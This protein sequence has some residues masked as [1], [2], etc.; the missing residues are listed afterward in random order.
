[1]AR[2]ARGGARYAARVTPQPASFI[3]ALFLCAIGLFLP[4]CAGESGDEAGGGGV[5]VVGVVSDL[6][7]GVDIA[8][9]RVVMRQGGRVIR[10]EV[11]KVS[12][13]AIPLTFPTE[14]RFDGLPDGEEVEVG[15]EAFKGYYSDEDPLVVRDARTR[16]VFGEAR[17]LRARI[18]RECIP[19]FRL[20][21]DLIA[22]ECARPETCVAAACADPYVPPSE[23]EAYSPGWA[24]DF[25]DACKGA[26]AGDPEILIGEGR[27]GYSAL[28]EGSV[29]QVEG[30]PQGGF[31]IWVSVRMRNLHQSGSTTAVTVRRQD[32]DDV[33]GQ[34]VSSQSYAAA[35]GEQCELA[36]LRCQLSLQ[37]ASDELG[38]LGSSL[39]VAASVSDLAGDVG[40]AEQVIT[41]S[42]DVVKE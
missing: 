7:P 32:T 17:L 9:L 4:G 3:A 21:G 30:G 14:L 35:G 33:L 20:A 16:A 28:S 8:R 37:S 42:S 18:E 29:V 22:P 27:G 36:G 23:L 40:I 1:M 41:L 39:R 38:L 10:D 6:V 5:I 12:G 34:F 13:G 25:V 24:E 31:H 15:L 2:A 19:S 11:R 26:E